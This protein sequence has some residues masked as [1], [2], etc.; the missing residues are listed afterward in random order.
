MINATLS[1]LDAKYSI[2]LAN[3]KL[4]EAKHIVIDCQLELLSH[5]LPI[6]LMP[7]VIGSFDII[8]GMDWLTKNQAE[9]ICAEKIVRIPIP[10]EEVLSVRGDKGGA[11]SGIISCLKAQK[12]LRKGHT[13]ILAVVTD[14]TVEEKKISG[15]P[16]VCEF[17]K[18]F[19]RNYQVSHRI[20]K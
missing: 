18:C 2:E 15:F 8:V 17:L 14:Q 12:C 3:G 4:I 10:G 20:V 16:I 13:A 19:P 1:P 11:I 7:I 5:K 9:I 6:D